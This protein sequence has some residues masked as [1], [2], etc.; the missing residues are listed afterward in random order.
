[1]NFG[2]RLDEI[3]RNAYSGEV[4]WI[5][6]QFDDTSVLEEVLGGVEKEILN[7]KQSITSLL[8]ELVAEAKP[9]MPYEKLKSCPVCGEPQYNHSGDVHFDYGVNQYEENLLK[10]LGCEDEK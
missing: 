5:H 3:V 1:M 7:T 8:K 10:V 6:D 2:L 4:S 9:E